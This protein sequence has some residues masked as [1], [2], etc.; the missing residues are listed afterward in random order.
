MLI[1][2]PAPQLGETLQRPE[3]RNESSFHKEQRPYKAH[4]SKVRCHAVCKAGSNAHSSSFILHAHSSDPSVPLTAIATVATPRDAPLRQALPLHFTFA[5]MP[6]SAASC[7]KAFCGQRSECESLHPLQ[8]HL[9][10]VRIKAAL[11]AHGLFANMVSPTCSQTSCI[12]ATTAVPCFLKA[13]IHL[14]LFVF[15]WRSFCVLSSC[16]R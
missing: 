12:P 3:H 8:Q 5:R 13:S 10:S 6:P 2:W 7:C 9:R 16:L 14:H 4:Q 11:K 15:E 1:G